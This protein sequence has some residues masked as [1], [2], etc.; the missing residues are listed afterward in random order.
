MLEELLK[1]LISA[2]PLGVIIGFLVLHIRELN[3]EVRELNAKA[4]QAANEHTKA[5]NEEKNARISDANVGFSALFKVQSD[6]RDAIHKI[7]DTAQVLA[8]RDEDLD[9]E[10]RDIVR[11]SVTSEGRRLPPRR[12][13][14]DGG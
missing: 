5:Q 14:D 8:R 2:G 1:T 7:G 10:A 3:K 4:L 11:S 9:R 13:S 6:Y 12:G